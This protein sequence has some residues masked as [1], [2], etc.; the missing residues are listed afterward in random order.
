MLFVRSRM[1]FE[2][3]TWMPVS[4]DR[5]PDGTLHMTAPKD[6]LFKNSNVD[7]YWKYNNDA[8]LF[9]LIC[10]R[11]HY[12][13]CKNV[14]LYMPYCPH[15]RM[16]NVITNITNWIKDYF[17]NNG[18]DCKAIIGISG[19]KDSTVTAALLV[20][21]LGKNRVIGVKMPQGNQHDI[22]VANKVIDYLGI[23]SYE[24]NIG[25]VCESLYHAID[26]GYDFDS[27][28][29][30]NPQVTS[31][32]PARVRMTV[33]YAI[34]A[35][36]HGRVA[37]TCNR[38]EDFIG[39]STKFGDAAGDFSVLSEYTVSEVRQIGKAL[40]IPNEFIFKA[41]EDGL[42]GKTDEDNLGFT[43]GELDH[44]LLRGHYPSYDVYKNIEE[45]HKR[46]LHKI[47]PMPSCPRYY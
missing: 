37:N 20:K 18:P 17:V 16:E 33:L 32:S 7:I 24:I 14:T 3:K 34:A 13:D 42:S 9:S 45:R 35:L 26:E 21:A 40:G 23:R 4:Q 11:K 44:F 5:F 6:S 31:N 39:Y 25:D 30:N 10:L 1:G 27:T 38:S 29:K 43:Y 15:A 36:E 28:V 22:D 41:P 47:N 46:N 8:E 12:A 2:D 19:G